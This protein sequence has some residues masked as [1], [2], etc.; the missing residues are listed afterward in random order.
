MAVT[1][2]GD[3]RV[4]VGSQSSIFDAVEPIMFLVKVK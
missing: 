4:W 1:V 2:L 3:V